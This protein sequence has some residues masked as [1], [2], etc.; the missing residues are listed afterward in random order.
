[1]S[2][3]CYGPDPDRLLVAER[4]GAGRLHAQWHALTETETAVVAE[5]WEIAGNRAALLAE[6]AGILLGLP[7]G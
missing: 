5:L 6:V 3:D 2:R 4:R 1:M 7:R